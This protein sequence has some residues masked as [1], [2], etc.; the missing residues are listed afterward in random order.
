M[1]D[2]RAQPQTNGDD[3]SD[4]YTYQNFAPVAVKDNYTTVEDQVLTVSVQNGVLKNDS[5]ENNDA[6]FV[7]SHSQASNGAITIDRYG[8]V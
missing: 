5:D 2:G 4:K 1:D 6:I 7:K 3:T 8:A